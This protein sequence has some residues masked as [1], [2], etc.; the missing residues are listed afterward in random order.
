MR[1]TFIISIDFNYIFI[2]EVF[3]EHIVPIRD[4]LE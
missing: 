1:S 2:K 3:L 4:H